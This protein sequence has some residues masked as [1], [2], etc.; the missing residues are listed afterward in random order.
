MLPEPK[1]HLNLQR[2]LKLIAHAKKQ[3]ASGYLEKHH[4]LPKAMGG[5]NDESNIAVLTARQHY[6]AHKLLWKAYK[7]RETARAFF[8]MSHRTNSKSKLSSKSYEALKEGMSVSDITKQKLSN[9]FKGKKRPPFTAETKAKM[10]AVRIGIEFSNETKA[11][12][13][14]SA[15]QRVR[16][17]HSLESKEKMK[18]AAKARE[19]AKKAAGYIVSEETRQKLSIAS[20]RAHKN[21]ADLLVTLRNNKPALQPCQKPSTVSLS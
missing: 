1:S 19:L 6:I 20:K 3:C 13:S 5:S 4:V 16:C 7:T 8:F 10:S 21:K 18:I 14:E 15:K 17:L 11:K 2:Y 12:M 9:A